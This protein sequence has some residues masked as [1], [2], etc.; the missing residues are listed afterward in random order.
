MKKDKST[1]RISHI[2]DATFKCIVEKGYANVTMNAIAE[3]AGLSK[4]AITHYFKS[5]QDIMIAVLNELDTKLYSIVNKI[6]EETN[7]K[8]DLHYRLGLSA[9]F[10]LIHD[11]FTLMFVIID[12]LSQASNNT[13]YASIIKSFIEKYRSLSSD[14]VQSGSDAGVYK[15][16]KTENIGAIVVALVL[17]IGIQRMIDKE[18]FN[19]DEISAMAEEIVINYIAR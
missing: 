5:K 2:V 3:Y 6:K 9:G 14:G 12:F 8:E 16:V 18:Q 7:S 1:D 11:D 17:G 4:G 19:F 15:H 13:E 10:Q